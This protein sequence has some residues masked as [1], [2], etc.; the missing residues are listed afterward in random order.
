VSFNDGLQ[1]AQKN[2]LVF[3]E[4]SAV[5]SEGVENAFMMAA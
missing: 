4:T 1:F 5:T 2:D 3:F